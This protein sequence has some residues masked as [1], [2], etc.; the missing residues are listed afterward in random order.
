MKEDLFV[1]RK[2]YK[3]IKEDIKFNLPVATIEKELV[4]HIENQIDSDSFLYKYL[5]AEKLN[6]NQCSNKRYKK[7]QF[8]FEEDNALIVLVSKVCVFHSEFMKLGGT[9]AK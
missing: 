5:T 4:E 2:L 7:I 6:P 8:E 1:C 9:N 3:K